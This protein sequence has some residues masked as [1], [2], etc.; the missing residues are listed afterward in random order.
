L[1]FFGLATYPEAALREKKTAALLGL[2]GLGPLSTVIT[3][4]L[5][6]A[7]RKRGA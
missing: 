7:L 1:L 3:R 2:L 4:Q 6:Q 5:A